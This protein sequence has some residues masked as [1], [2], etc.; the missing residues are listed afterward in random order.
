VSA[1]IDCPA[2]DADLEGVLLFALSYNGYQRLAEDVEQLA[3]V[4]APVLEHLEAHGAPPP[5]AGY[6]LLRGALFFLQ[7]QSHHW[8]LVPPD[9]EARMRR[10]IDAIGRSGGGPWEDDREFADDPRTEV[11]AAAR[12]LCPQPLGHDDALQ[13][14]VASIGWSPE[15]TPG[16]VMRYE[17][18]RLSG[19][20]VRSEPAM[21]AVR[22]MLQDEP[23]RH[24]SWRIRRY[25]TLGA[26][27]AAALR[28]VDIG[29]DLDEVR[30]LLRSSLAGAWPTGGTTSTG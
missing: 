30:E 9:Q 11:M 6:D 2:A 13:D 28:S 10:L 5:W 18:L 27:L 20:D 3:G 25:A 15:S 8:G 17:A 16:S 21:D 12:A 23:F 14:L 4:V 22:R 29:E 1:Y 24:Q 7:R 26:L 19:V